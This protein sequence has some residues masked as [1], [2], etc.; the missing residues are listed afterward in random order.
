MRRIMTLSLT[1]L[2]FSATQ[3]FSQAPANFLEGTWQIISQ[4]E[5]HTDTVMVTQDVP[6]SIKILNSSHFSWGYQTADGE[7]VLAGG[8]KYTLHGDSLYVEHIEYH[9]SGPR[10]GIDLEFQV[11]VVGDSLWYH[12]GVF[13]TGF[14]LE[15]VWRRIAP[16]PRR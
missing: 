10:V 5:V 2:M 1:L 4:Q 12:T 11:R 13:P 6:P 3:A 7:E 15:E 16:A 9:T 8:G 14:R